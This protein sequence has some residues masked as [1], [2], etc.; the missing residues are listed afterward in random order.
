MIAHS[1]VP[2]DIKPISHTQNPEIANPSLIALKYSKGIVFATVP[3]GVIGNN[4]RYKNIDRFINVSNNVIVSSSGD[5]SDFQELARILQ[6]KSHKAQVYSGKREASVDDIANNIAH[7]CYE[8]RDKQ[9]PYYLQAIVGGVKNDEKKLFYVDM[10]GNI[11]QDKYICTGFSLMICPP[12][13]DRCYKEDMTLEEAQDLLVKCFQ[14]LVARQ[15]IIADVVSF[16]IVNKDGCQ[17]E[18]R[19]ISIKYDFESYINKEQFMKTN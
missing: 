3:I 10:Y 9:D 16:A 6:E 12:I 4:I 2:R 5:Y 19:R 8:K 13:I 18:K 15:T 1:F 14:A 7:M 11:F 17:F